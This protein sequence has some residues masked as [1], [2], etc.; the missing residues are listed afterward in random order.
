[1]KISNKQQI[2]QAYIVIMIMIMCNISN[3]QLSR[4]EKYTSAGHHIELNNIELIYVYRFCLGSSSPLSL[5]LHTIL[6]MNNKH[7]IIYFKKCLLEVLFGGDL[8]DGHK[9][10]VSLTT[11][12]NGE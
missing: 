12:K 11:N 1:M 10:V 8:L 3:F 5:N 2:C 6:K 4:M 7:L 9:Y